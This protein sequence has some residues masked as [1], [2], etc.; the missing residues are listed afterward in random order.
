MTINHVV[1]LSFENRVSGSDQKLIL[2]ATENLMAVVPSVRGYESGFDLGLTG[3]AAKSYSILVKFDS[4]EAYNEYKN[5]PAHI[6]FVETYL[7]PRLSR[8]GRKAIQYEVI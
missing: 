2:D 6:E 1:I 4:A 8:E 7:K 5:H 3:D